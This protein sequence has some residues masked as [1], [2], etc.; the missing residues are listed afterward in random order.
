MISDVPDAVEESQS[1][2]L[3][4]STLNPL[5]ATRFP[6]ADRE[7]KDAIWRVLCPHFFQRYVR[8]EDV[9]LDIG[10]GFGEFLRHI[11]C[12][13]RIAVDIERLAGRM[14]PAGTEEVFTP[15]DRLSQHV[16]ANSVDVIF[17]S[18]FF[19]HLPT[20]QIFLTTLKEIHTVLR[21]GGR[22]LALQPN[23]RLVGGA[24]WDFVD[25]H[26]PL[27]DRTLVEACESLGYEIVEVVPRFLPYTTRSAI[28]QSPWL[29]RLYLMVRPAW[30][31]LGKQTWLV[32]RKKR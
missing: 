14:L 6:E 29:V 23:I 15:S 20:T 8:A 16:P 7:A 5:Y 19:E 4:E 3:P 31:F 17:C 9:V 12:A 27:T 21:P 10:A 22:L 25:H 32:A 11:R 18:N 24:Y 30:W 13:R 28:P 2:P 1:S 26:L